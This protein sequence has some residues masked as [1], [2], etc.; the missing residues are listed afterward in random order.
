MKSVPVMEISVVIAVIF[1]KLHLLMTV[2]LSVKAFVCP[3]TACIALTILAIL[4][5]NHSV[6]SEEQWEEKE[7]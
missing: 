2:H 4:I 1:Q 5:N 7:C 6:C 3:Y